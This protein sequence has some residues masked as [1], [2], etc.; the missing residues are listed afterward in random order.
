MVMI[1]VCA[2]LEADFRWNAVTDRYNHRAC[3]VLL[4]AAIPFWAACHIHRKGSFM[5]EVRS[6]SSAGNAVASG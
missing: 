2:D 4:Q 3:D 6:D 5:P 1:G